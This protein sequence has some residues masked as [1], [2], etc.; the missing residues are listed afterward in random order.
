METCIWSE[1]EVE[2]YSE[3]LSQ[4]LSVNTRQFFI[5]DMHTI[6][7]CDIYVCSEVYLSGVG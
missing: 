2:V 5:I 7:P 3:S 6:S 4:E 1:T